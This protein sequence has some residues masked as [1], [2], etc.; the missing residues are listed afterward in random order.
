M[1]I[2]GVGEDVALRGFVP[3]PTRNAPTGKLVRPVPPLQSTANCPIGMCEYLP[4]KLFSCASSRWQL[5]LRE[6]A[7]S[8]C[9]T[10]AC[11]PW[12]VRSGPAKGC[13][14]APRSTPLP[15]QT[16]YRFQGLQDGIG[17]QPVGL[18][19]R[20][21]KYG[22]DV[23]PRGLLGLGRGVRRDGRGSRRT[24]RG[25][26]AML[27]RTQIELERPGLRRLRVRPDGRE[28]CSSPSAFIFAARRTGTVRSD[29][30]S[31]PCAVRMIV[32]SG[33]S[34]WKASASHGRTSPGR[35]RP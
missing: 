3:F 22:R 35:Q 6:S 24:R 15:G 33:G 25:C 13:A 23:I 16:D 21:G 32:C 4:T 29:P 26:A 28:I 34:A 14:G 18:R 2:S 19:R 7:P 5:S 30:T 11:G 10:K 17:G 27:V 9:S 12:S 1:S 8:S 20:T 31:T